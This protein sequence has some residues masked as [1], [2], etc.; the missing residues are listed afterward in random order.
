VQNVIIAPAQEG[1]GRA[2]E[3]LCLARVSANA[4][5]EGGQTGDNIRPVW[6]MFGATENELRPFAANLILGR[7]AL[8]PKSHKKD[9]KIEFLK[10]VRYQQAWQREA[11]GSLVTLFMPD[12]FRHDPGMVDPKG[13]S[14]VLLVPKSWADKEDLD[15][16]PMMEYVLGLGFPK[17]RIEETAK[18][19][20]LF[21][22]YLD[23]RT[24]CPIPTDGR[25]Y[26]QLLY[27][28]LQEGLATYA[29]SEG[30]SS[31]YRSHEFGNHSRFGFYETNTDQVGLLPGIAVHSSHENFERLLAEQVTLFFSNIGSK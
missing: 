27:A 20:Y 24:R 5:W 14:F 12:L 19:A 23:R 4:L 16:R 1:K 17:D 30:Y 15:L 21:A 6:A 7:K 13:I 8:F 28:C 26:L 31:S 10:S 2:F 18:L 11:E 22:T 9:E 25:F 29:T 3:A